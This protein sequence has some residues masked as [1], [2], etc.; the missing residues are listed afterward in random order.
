[1]VKIWALSRSRHVSS[2]RNTRKLSRSPFR[3]LNHS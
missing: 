3:N 2:G 1:V